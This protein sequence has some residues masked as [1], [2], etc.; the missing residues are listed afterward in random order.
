MKNSNNPSN[1]PS[2][3]SQVAKLSLSEII[4]YHRDRITTGTTAVQDVTYQVAKS[5]FLAEQQGKN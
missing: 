2:K 4:G 5:V 3:L 1:S